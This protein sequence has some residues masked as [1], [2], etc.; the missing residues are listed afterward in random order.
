MLHCRD[1]HAWDPARDF[2]AGQ[3]TGAACPIC[4]QP[5]LPEGITY[6]E[7]SLARVFL[8]IGVV[9]LVLVGLPFALVLVFHVDAQQLKQN[10]LLIVLVLAPV[11]VVAVV[12][13]TRRSRRKHEAVARGLGFSYSARLYPEFRETVS[14][15]PLVGNNPARN[16]LSGSYRGTPVLLMTI[17][18]PGSL[19]GRG[20]SRANPRGAGLHAGNQAAFV[21]R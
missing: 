3:V 19:H 6:W 12:F 5:P 17:G 14:K 9:V 7:P 13:F 10:E 16:C 11:V 1:D 21:G 15:L 18:G 2:G 8:I 4:T 20:L